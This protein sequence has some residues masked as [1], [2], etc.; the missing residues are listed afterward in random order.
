[1]RRWSVGWLAAALA[2]LLTGAMLLSLRYGTTHYSLSEIITGLFIDHSSREGLILSTVRLP[3]LAATVLIGASLGVAGALMQGVTRNPLASPSVFGVNAG[4]AF[5]VVLMIVLFPAVPV[6]WRVC[7]ALIGAI[8]S[9]TLVFALSKIIRFGK[10][11]VKMALIGVTMQTFLAVGTQALLLLNESKAEQA[12]YWLAGS[13]V[14]VR[15]PAIAILACWCAVG[16][17]LA[18]G[19][20]R[21]LAALSL[22]DEVA[23]SLGQQVRRLRL[24]A[25]C[26]VVMLAGASVAV[27]GPIG[28]V[29]L[30]VPHIVRYM[31]GV[32]YRVVLP[33]SGLLGALLLTG[34][35][36]CSRA[37]SYPGETPV[38]IVTALIGTPYFIYLARRQGGRMS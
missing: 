34:A 4:A 11:E 10:P 23:A 30:M 24:M 22:G 35:D 20:S 8:G 21:S 7:G 18:L 14:G 13:V 15:W 32:H 31:A 19:L 33:L 29:G 17:A 5:A 12:M 37:I 28:F 27:A 16:L 36:V 26:A 9:V 6:L 2:A 38:G 3:R 25:V 1:M